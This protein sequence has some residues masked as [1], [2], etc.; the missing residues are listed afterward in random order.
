MD[1]NVIT[2]ILDILPE[3]LDNKLYHA[4]NSAKQKESRRCRRHSI[5]SQ[6]MNCRSVIGSQSQIFI[7]AALRYDYD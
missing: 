6:K 5:V 7:N 4:L 3:Y 2:R 1:N